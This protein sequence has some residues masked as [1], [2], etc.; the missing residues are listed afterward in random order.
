MTP[1]TRCKQRK[2][3]HCKPTTTV[4]MNISW[5]YVTVRL[6]KSV[7]KEKEINILK[8]GFYPK[9]FTVLEYN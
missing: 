8:H 5:P 9:M 3:P 7:F 2:L 1:R 6:K 4:G